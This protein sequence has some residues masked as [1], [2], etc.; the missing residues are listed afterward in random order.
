I[1]R[2]RSFVRGSTIRETCSRAS[3]PRSIFL[4]QPSPLLAT[5]RSCCP[6]AGG[7]LG[8]LKRCPVC[9]Y[10][11]SPLHSFLRSSTGFSD[12]H[13]ST[14]GSVTDPLHSFWPVKSNSYWIIFSELGCPRK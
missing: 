13:A 11:A 1:L 6:S 7:C 5:G 12:P 8:G 4:S 2:R 10:V 3:N 14:D 9:C